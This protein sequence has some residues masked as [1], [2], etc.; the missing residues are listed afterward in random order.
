[1]VKPPDETAAVVQLPAA[2]L[3]DARS[4]DQQA[5]SRVL[6]AILSDADTGRNLSSVVLK[7]GVVRAREIGDGTWTRTVWRR[8]GPL[9][10]GE[11]LINAADLAIQME[12]RRE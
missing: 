1:M 12:P 4:L 9:V 10:V 6:T 5:L 2:S 8:G 3:K 11:E 7:G